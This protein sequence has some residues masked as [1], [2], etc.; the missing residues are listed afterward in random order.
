[1]YK[2]IGERAHGL[3]RGAAW[4]CGA[5]PGA[6]WRGLLGLRWCRGFVGNTPQQWCGMAMV[7]PCSG[8]GLSICRALCSGLAHGEVSRALCVEQ[9]RAGTAVSHV[10]A[11]ESRG[12]GQAWRDPR[13]PGA[14]ARLCTDEPGK[15][16]AGEGMRREWPVFKGS[17][18]LVVYLPV[19][20]WSFQPSR[21]SH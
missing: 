9:A 5:V 12:T 14:A 11:Q 18:L 16:G 20:R 19:L 1:M 7:W 8:Q 6:D 4:S 13:G 2:E 21:G 3:G 15:A 17:S 10:N